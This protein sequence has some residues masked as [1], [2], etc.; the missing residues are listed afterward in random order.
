MKNTIKKHADFAMPDD[1]P[2]FIADGFIMRIRPTIF[3][4][5]RLGF[6]AT[7]KTVGK[8]AHDRNL[9]KR[10]LRALAREYGLPAA[11]PGYDFVFIARS[12]MGAMD[13]AELRASF[14]RGLQKLTAR[15][16]PGIINP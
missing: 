1:M 7:K 11:Y 2:K 4:S 8:R 10:R 5:G 9:A 16:K 6:T 14:G 3:E 15:M 12:G 13:F